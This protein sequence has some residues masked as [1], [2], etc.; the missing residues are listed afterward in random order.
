MVHVPDVALPPIDPVTGITIGKDGA[1]HTAKSVPA[2]TVTIG[3]TVTVTSSIGPL[4]P[5]AAGVIWYTT[6]PIELF[7]VLNVCVINPPLPFDAPLTLA[8]GVTVHENVVPV[9]FFGNAEMAIDA[10]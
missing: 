2:F 10:F 5:P 3:L 9:T 6:L 7:V 4:Q 1:S 8:D